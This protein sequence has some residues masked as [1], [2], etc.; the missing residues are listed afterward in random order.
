MWLLSD[1]NAADIN[2]PQPGTVVAGRIEADHLGAPSMISVAWDSTDLGLTIG[3]Y[4]IFSLLAS[5]VGNPL[6]LMVP[7]DG[8]Q[9]SRLIK[10]L[11][12]GGTLNL[13]PAFFSFPHHVSHQIA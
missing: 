6:I 3:E 13:L 4:N 2:D 7:R 9:E 1:I 12:R 5:N 10:G 11:A 8:L